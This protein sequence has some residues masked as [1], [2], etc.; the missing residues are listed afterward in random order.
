MQT[1]NESIDPRSVHE[2]LERLKSG[3]AA[4]TAA[5]SGLAEVQG[6]AACRPAPRGP[7]AAEADAEKLEVRIHAS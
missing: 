7:A 5:E 4:V 3:V 6:G 1:A 2:R